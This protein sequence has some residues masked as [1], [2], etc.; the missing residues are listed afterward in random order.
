M[1]VPLALIG[2]GKMLLAQGLPILAN[3]VLTKGKEV[4]E[5]KIGMK[6]PDIGQ[7]VSEDHLF[8]LKQAEIQH[9]EFLLDKIMEDK[10]LDI[11]WLKTESESVTKRWQFD[12]SSDSKLSKNV[13]PGVLVYFMLL[14]TLLVLGEF[15][16]VKV[17]DR[18]FDMI[19]SFGEI[20]FV[21]Y[22]GGRTI[23]KGIGML[24]DRIGT[25]K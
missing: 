9:E 14:I 5:D 1:A 18:L 21:A 20:V 10:K 2:L 6:L 13:R 12:M 11:D 3:A 24:K 4:V 16:E 23:E 15:F 22:F 25:K 19:Q 17:G 8:K 7:P